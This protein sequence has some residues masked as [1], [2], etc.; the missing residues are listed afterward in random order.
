VLSTWVKENP[1]LFDTEVF[2]FDKF[3]R[4]FTSLK[5]NISVYPLES[6]FATNTLPVYEQSKN[7]KLKILNTIIIYYDC[8]NRYQ[9]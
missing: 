4:K 7:E 9:I 8:I 3:F 1:E 6:L 2:V 5:K